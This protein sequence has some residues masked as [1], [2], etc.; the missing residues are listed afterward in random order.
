MAVA[1]RAHLPIFGFDQQITTV[2]KLSRFF[3]TAL[4]VLMLASCASH[5]SHKHKKIKPGKPMPCPLK[6]C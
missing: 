5:H 4:I 3:S 6:D 1:Q 2:Q